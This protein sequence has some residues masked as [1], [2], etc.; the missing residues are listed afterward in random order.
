MKPK[1]YIFFFIF[2]A[3]SVLAQNKNNYQV[4][5]V[6]IE[7]DNYVTI[8]IWNT[9]YGKKYS[10]DDAR[11]DAVHAI[12][13]SGVPYKNG[14]IAQK[15]ILS[16]PEAAENFEKIQKDFFKKNC[17]WAKYTRSSETEN[18]LPALI[19]DKK[20]KVYK[21]YVAKNLLRKDLEDQKIIKSLNSGF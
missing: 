8:K 2:I 16:T 9:K 17:V 21:V 13:F 10:Q 7:N 15:P 1:Y 14:C 20:W 6:S 11:K 12:L 18:T 3:S 5:C 4:E 19:G